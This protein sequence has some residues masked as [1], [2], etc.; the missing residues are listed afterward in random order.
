[1]GGLEWRGVAP[2][3][4]FRILRTPPSTLPIP[5]PLEGA[6]WVRGLAA[7]TPPHREWRPGRSSRA[8]TLGAGTGVPARVPPTGQVV[9][10]GRGSSAPPAPGVRY[11]RVRLTRTRPLRQL[12]R[13]PRG[14]LSAGP[15]QGRPG[16]P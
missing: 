11:P 13:R 1:M 9:P 2:R 14:L 6:L 5:R 15:R 16:V 10:D 8:P 12:P 4:V 7:R 3:L